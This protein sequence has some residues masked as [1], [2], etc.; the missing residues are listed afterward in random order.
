MKG[1][2]RDAILNTCHGRSKSLKRITLLMLGKH[3]KAS[4]N[5]TTR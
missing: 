1:D 5:V 2:E 3:R 4:Y